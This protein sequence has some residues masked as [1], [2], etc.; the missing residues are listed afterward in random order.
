MGSPGRNTS[1]SI[2][3]DFS[4]LMTNKVLLEQIEKG[5]NFVSSTL[6]LRV[7]MSQNQQNEVNKKRDGHTSGTFVSSFLWKYKKKKNVG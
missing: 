4:L 2:N 7:M 6:S 1:T 5:S 3:T